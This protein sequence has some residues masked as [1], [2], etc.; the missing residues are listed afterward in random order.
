MFQRIEKKG[1]QVLALH[2]AEAILEHDMSS[3][4]MNSKAC[5]SMQRFPLKNWFV[6][7]GEKGN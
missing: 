4:S 1:F 3:L 2:H 5:F 7:E 6:A